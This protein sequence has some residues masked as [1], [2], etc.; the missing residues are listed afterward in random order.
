MSRAI[1]IDVNPEFKSKARLGQYLKSW[2]P[3]RRTGQSR[4]E[5]GSIGRLAASC[6]EAS[7]NGGKPS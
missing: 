2:V 3:G 4:K 1:D 6:D 5:L 7:S